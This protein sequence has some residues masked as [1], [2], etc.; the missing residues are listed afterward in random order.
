MSMLEQRFVG[1]VANPNII[2]S[3]FITYLHQSNESCPRDPE[4]TN[5]YECSLTYLHSMITLILKRFKR[6]NAMAQRG[7][8]KLKNTRI[9]PKQRELYKR[10][11]YSR[12]KSSKKWRPREGRHEMQSMRW[13]Y[14]LW[15]LLQPGWGFF[16]MEVH[17]LR[18]D[19]WSGYFR[20]SSWYA[21]VI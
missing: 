4:N 1:V 10:L 21:H 19:H 7:A 18:R 3:T 12:L 6:D 5:W 8:E 15:E 17:F 11:K 14:G 13:S 9:S 20:E 2:Q 16:W